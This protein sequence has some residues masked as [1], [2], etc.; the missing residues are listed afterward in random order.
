MDYFSAVLGFSWLVY[1]WETYLAKRQH[2]IYKTTKELPVELTSVIDEKTFDKSREYAIDKSNFGFWHGLFSQFETTIFLW[3]ELIPYLWLGAGALMSLVGLGPEYEII[4]S[5]VF[6]LLGNLISLVVGMPW[7]L[8]STF[9]IEEKHGFNKMTVGFFFKDTL[10][11]MVVS[12]AISMPLIATIIYVVKVG[13]EYFYVYVWFV[14]FVISMIL[15]HIYPEFIAPLFDKYTPL[16]EG[17]LKTR[18]EELAASLDYPL[19]KIYVVEGSK[20]SSHSNAY[21]YGFYKNKRIVLFD[22]LLEDYTPVAGADEKDKVAKEEEASKEEAGDEQKLGKD[23]EK[24]EKEQKKIGCNT[25]EVVAVLGHELGH[26]YYSHMVKNLLIMQANIIFMFFMFGVL[27][28]KNEIFAA[29]GFVDYQPVLIK[30]YIVFTFIFSP[31]NEIQSFLMNVLSRHFEFQADEFAVNLGK[32]EFLKTALLK[33]TKDNLSFPVADR[34]Y[35]THHYSHP[36]LLERLK[37][38]DD[39]KVKGD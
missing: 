18:I 33:L 3:Y 25:D 19:T 28:K 17:D 32:K 34:L 10:K 22:T 35:S 13:G 8:Y 37:G 7:N 23:D 2:K 15:L 39:V 9:V 5:L 11:K 31:F 14:V 24:E 12:E 27:M 30:L 29:F 16:P 21:M 38:M 36:P 1:I 6:S 4:H 20:R 26:W